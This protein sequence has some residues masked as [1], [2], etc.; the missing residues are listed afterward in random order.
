MDKMHKRAEFDLTRWTSSASFS[1]IESEHVNTYSLAVFNLVSLVEVITTVF[2]AFLE[3]I[4][5]MLFQNRL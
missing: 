3:R 1:S 2:K 5:G 4:I